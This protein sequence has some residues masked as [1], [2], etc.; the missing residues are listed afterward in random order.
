MSP[1]FRNDTYIFESTIFQIRFHRNDTLDHLQI[2]TAN[3]LRIHIS[4][5]TI[6]F[7]FFLSYTRFFIHTVGKLDRRNIAIM[8][9]RGWLKMNIDS[10]GEFARGFRDR[11]FKEESLEA[12]KV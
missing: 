9:V 12:R 6:F 4:K 2:I 10:G 11:R 5:V 8:V 7:F 3:D 1:H